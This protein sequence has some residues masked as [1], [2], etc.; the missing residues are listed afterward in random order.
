M[1]SNKKSKL[2]KQQAATKARR[3]S[4]QQG[5]TGAKATTKVAKPTKAEQRK[6]SQ[7]TMIKVA[8]V[9]FAAIL[10]FSMMLPSCSSIFAGRVPEQ[11][12]A[13]QPQSEEATTDEA[14]QDATTDEAT[15][16]A[17]EEPAEELTGIALAD[18]HYQP[19]VDDLKANLEANPSDLASILNLG[20]YYMDWGIEAASSARTDEETLYVYGLFDEAIAYFDRYLEINDSKDIRSRRALC[21][22][23]SGD[24]QEGIASLEE[25]TAEVSDYA[26]AWIYLGVMYEASGRGDDALAAYLKATETDPDDLYGTRSYATE[27][28]AALNGTADSGEA[29]ASSAAPTGQSLQDVLSGAS[30]TG[31]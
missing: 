11:A 23:Y 22:Y 6:Q 14:T 29:D 17:G 2:A 9:V 21:M 24:T 26:P 1:A 13:E 15:Q 31:Y 16:D 7:N 3:E 8:A 18:S 27:R 28:I 4:K 20:N 19:L 30:G 10:G 5:T 12:P 25:F